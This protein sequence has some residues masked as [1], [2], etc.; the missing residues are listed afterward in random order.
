MTRDVRSVTRADVARLAGVSSAV[1]SYVVND[2]PRPVAAATALRV[3]EAMDLLGY[4]PNASARALRTGTTQTLGLVLGDSRNPFFTEYTFELVK[5]AAGLG[6]HVLIGDAHQ[7]GQGDPAAIVEALV[8]RQVDGLLFAAPHHGWTSRLAAA[9]PVPFVLVDA[10][11]PMPG[12][13]S[14]GSAARAG[15]HELTRHLIADG[16]RHVALLI[17]E[18]G[19]GHPDPRE[20]GWLSAHVEAA[21]RPGPVMRTSFTREG[22]YAGTVRLLQGQEQVDAIFASNDLQ[23][24]GALRA[25]HEHGRPIPGDIALV[26]YDGTIE[27]EFAWPPLTVAR[28]NVQ[29]M[30]RAALDLLAGPQPSAGRHVEI[31]TQ[32][33]IR[34]SC[35][36]PVATTTAS[37]RAKES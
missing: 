3:R 34:A 16:R 10:P 25:L 26:S 32:L 20:A 7:Y 4:R 33:I 5:A 30:A 37:A 24:I 2:G 22:G 35:G 17:G 14:V 31:A 18:E 21:V 36:C 12:V 27:A 11:G 9:S 1:V 23:A 6:K 8:A 13:R 15:A 28:Q 29:A 19:F